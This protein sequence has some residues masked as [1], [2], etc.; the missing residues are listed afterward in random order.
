MNPWE[1]NKADDEKVKLLQ[2]YRT[3]YQIRISVPLS[4]MRYSQTG[5][6]GEGGASGCSALADSLITRPPQLGR[7]MVPSLQHIIPSHHGVLW[8]AK[9]RL[10]S[11]P[12]QEDPVRSSSAGV[13]TMHKGQ[14]GVFR[15]SGSTIADVPGREQISGA[16][17]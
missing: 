11:M 8:E 7:R 16:E 6:M 15:I 14:A 5:R 9:Q 3:A 4:W 17:G 2:N 12:K 13:F 1:S 10:W